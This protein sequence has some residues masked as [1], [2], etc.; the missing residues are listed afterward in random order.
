MLRCCFTSSSFF[1]SFAHF[2]DKSLN[3]DG[4]QEPARS[5]T[6]TVVA[7]TE[8]SD[9]PNIWGLNLKLNNMKT[10]IDILD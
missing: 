9:R 7:N 6:F 10:T 8:F 2:L 3:F 5:K 1:P 4:F